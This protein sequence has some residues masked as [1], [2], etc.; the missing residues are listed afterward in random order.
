MLDE[1]LTGSM[2]IVR[3]NSVFDLLVLNK[4]EIINVDFH[5]DCK[6]DT[7]LSIYGIFD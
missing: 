7:N 4:Y 3:I 1:S 6:Y 5:P 2:F